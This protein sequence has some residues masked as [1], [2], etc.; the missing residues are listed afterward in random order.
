M[1]GAQD[2]DHRDP[3]VIADG[4]H[5]AASKHI[6]GPTQPGGGLSRAARALGV[7]SGTERLYQPSRADRAAIHAAGL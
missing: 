7:R 1:C 5:H 3:G 4:A 2:R 6:T